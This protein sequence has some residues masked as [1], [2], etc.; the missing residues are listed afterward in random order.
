MS[1]SPEKM[2]IQRDEESLR[3]RPPWA[4][5][6]WAFVGRCDGCLACV[7]VCREGVLNPG[8]DGLPE[9]D[10]RF[11][12]CNFCGACVAACDRGALRRNLASKTPAF[13]FVLTVDSNCLAL[14]GE[15]CRTC[16]EFCDAYA[17]RFRPTERGNMVPTVIAANCSGCGACVGPCPVGSIQLTRPGVPV[18]T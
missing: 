15:P 7:D 17:I 4:I 12:G 9:M 5:A 6:E 18:T 11:G 3:P 8:K 13:R 16:E 2:F 1:A 10:F 14:A